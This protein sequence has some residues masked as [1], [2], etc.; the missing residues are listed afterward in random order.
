[1]Q[2]DAASR[3]EGGIRC[4]PEGNLGGLGLYVSLKKL[5]TTKMDS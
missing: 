2:S 3:E 1:M 4:L 5:F